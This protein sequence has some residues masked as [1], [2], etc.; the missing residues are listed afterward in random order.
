MKIPLL[1]FLLLAVTGCLVL[2]GEV[3]FEKLTLTEDFH[4]EGIAVADLDG[5]GQADVVSGPYWYRGPDFRTRKRYASGNDLS[6]KGYSQHFFTWA[7]DFNDDGFMD[8]LT[9][10]MPGD[11]AFWFQHP[12]GDLESDA[13]WVKHRVREDI[14]NE[15]PAFLDIDGDSVPELVCIHRGAYGYIKHQV[16]DGK[17]DFSFTPITPNL[18]YGRFTHGMGVGDV[19]GDGKVDLLETNGWWQQRAAGELFEFHPHRFAESGGSQM[20]AYDFDGDGDN[21]VLCSQNA[22]GF[23]LKWFEQKRDGDR[24]DF[25]P[26]TIM[27]DQA[28]DNPFGLAVSQMHAAELV[29]VDGDGI[30]DVVTGKRFWAHGG[31]DPGAEQLPLLFW[32]RTIRAN[33]RVIFEPH[34]IDLRS[35][36]GTQVTVADINQDGKTDVVTGSKMGSFIFLQSERETPL[37]RN[38]QMLL[39]G[40]GLFKENIRTTE[41]LSSEEQANT[42]I[43]PQGFEMQLVASEP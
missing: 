2:A 16:L 18:N 11:P 38:P 24:I 27:S 15:S 26:Q 9:V 23:G 29:D 5:D 41:P 12:G 20:F 13:I 4:S 34:L 1:S 21:D 25:A 35:G 6:I 30:K 28:S 17:V 3:A 32:L 36:V 7:F 14:S 37:Q 22:H 8:V 19:D 42:F 39:A 43:L 40:T 10:G 33:E 31:S